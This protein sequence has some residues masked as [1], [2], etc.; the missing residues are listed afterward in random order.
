MKIKDFL[1]AQPGVKRN[2]L[3]I[4]L[5]RV[6]DISRTEIILQEDRILNKDELATLKKMVDARKA[7]KPV[8]YILNE[9]EF[10]GRMFYVDGS[11]L[12]PRPETET[13]IDIIRE[14]YERDFEGRKIRIIDVGTGSGC[15]AVTLKLELKNCAGI[16]AVDKS[17]EA[18]SV[19]KKNAKKLGA[20][21]EFCESNLLGAVDGDFDIIVA[22]LPY[23]DTKWDWL[24][25]TTLGFGV[26]DSRAE[27]DNMCDKYMDALKQK[28]RPEF[29]NRIDDIILFSPL[30]KTQIIEII[31]LAL[32]SL[33]KRLSQRDMKLELTERA[34]NHIAD[35]AYDA[36]YGARP[37]KRYLQKHIETEIAPEVIHLTAVLFGRTSR[38]PVTL[39]EKRLDWSPEFVKFLLRGQVFSI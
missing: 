5:C 7:G 35:E 17:L 28:F 4:F 14:I 34:K 10:Y 6:L 30:T 13:A 29:L 2:E 20:E 26:A 37:V 11:V 36:H 39:K 18:L 23:V 32:S 16:L 9:K 38:S 25:K 8:A 21:V 33:E 3:E 22:N 19:A 12:I 1:K 15:I 24:D 27:Y 31:T